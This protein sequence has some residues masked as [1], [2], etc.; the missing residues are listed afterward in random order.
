MIKFQNRIIELT[1]T[2][3]TNSFAERLLKEKEV[4]EGTI[5]WAHEQ[6]AG[7][8]QGENVWL[9]EPGKNLTVTMI[10]YPRFL[11]VDRQFLLN[12]AIS[13]GVI[14]FVHT[15]LPPESVKIKW[16]N[17]ICH[18]YSKLGGILISNIITGNRFN[19]SVIGIGI[20]IN[21]T[22][23]EPSLPN[24]VSVKQAILKDTDTD[25]ALN[26]LIEMLDNRYDQLKNGGEHLLDLEYKNNLLGVNEERSF[27]R[28]KEIF[29]GIIRDVDYYGRL[30]IENPAKE[31]IAFSH[32]EIEFL[33]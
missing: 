15:L 30:I 17:D 11:P 33:F 4:R 14:D 13:L 12:K 9:S 22:R 3:S 8:G 23:F 18:H 28:D 6:T 2:D 31:R 19:T 26:V 7:K 20:N 25:Q 10:L 32:G 27:K 16:P 5:I 24:P 29:T 1:S 21:Q